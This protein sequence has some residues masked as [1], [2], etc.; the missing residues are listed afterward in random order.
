M[1]FLLELII[2]GFII[3]FLGV[4]IRCI[5]FRLFNK[6]VKKE[7][8]ENKHNDIVFGFTQGFYNAIVGIVTFILLSFGV[9]Y[10][11]YL[12]DLL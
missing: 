6:N 10:V 1:W 5:F 11:L 2:G 7:S 8:F 3:N 4:N 9:T 12:L